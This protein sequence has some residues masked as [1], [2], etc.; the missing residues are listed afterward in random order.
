[1]IFVIDT[2]KEDIIVGY[3]IQYDGKSMYRGV[4]A[5]KENMGNKILLFVAILGFMI[6]LIPACRNVVISWLIPFDLDV[7]GNA[8]ANFADSIQSGVPIRDAIV[9]FCKEILNHA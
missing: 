4:C 5:S 7:T 2:V 1:M 9:S 8:A 3:K 6:L